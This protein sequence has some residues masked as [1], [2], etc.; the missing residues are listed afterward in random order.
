VLWWCGV[1]EAEQCVD[2]GQACVVIATCCECMYTHGL[3]VFVNGSECLP[4][5]TLPVLVLVCILMCVVC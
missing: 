5:H 3:P 4:L 1:G 2:G